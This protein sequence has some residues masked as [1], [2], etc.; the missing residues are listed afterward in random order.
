MQFNPDPSKQAEEVYFLKK[1]NNVSSY[2]VTFN[3]IKVVTGSSQKHSRLVLDPQLNVNDHIQSKMTKWYKMIGIIKRSV[4]T[5][6]DAL[7]RV[8]KSVIRPHLDWRDI[9]YDKLN[10]ESFENIMENI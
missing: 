2:P 1:T 5:P 10:N 8:Y 7:L 6:R 4:K 9:I 3:N